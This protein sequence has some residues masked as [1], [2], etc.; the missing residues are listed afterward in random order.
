MQSTLLKL[1]IITLF[2]FLLAACGSQPAKKYFDNIQLDPTVRNA[3]GLNCP[4]IQKED[5]QQLLKLGQE[6]SDQQILDNYKL[7]GC[8]V[9]G[10]VSINDEVQKFVFEYGGLLFLENGKTLACGPSCCL[11]GFSYCSYINTKK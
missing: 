3:K 11:S 2:S 9:E 7:S 10:T 6:V 1:S 4:K 8:S 5:V